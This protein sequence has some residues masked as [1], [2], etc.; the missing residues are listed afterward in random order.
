VKYN[1]TTHHDSPSVTLYVELE[2]G[3][4][5]RVLQPIPGWLPSKR[6]LIMSDGVWL[7]DRRQP[8]PFEGKKISVDLNLQSL[9][10]RQDDGDYELYS[11]EYP[12]PELISTEFID[13]PESGSYDASVPSNGIA[14]GYIWL[15]V[16]GEVDL[17]DTTVSE[18]GAISIVSNLE[19]IL[20]KAFK[21]WLTQHEERF[22]LSPR[23]QEFTIGMS[24]AD[25]L[26][27]I[28]Q[29]EFEGEHALSWRCFRLLMKGEEVK[30]SVSMESLMEFLSS[31]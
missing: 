13:V 29:R 7:S 11:L 20:L 23:I 6:G 22:R 19:W 21:R 10:L 2:T 15:H 25:L 9:A 3:L 24:K 27:F 5:V 16:V 4:S 8:I 31:I 28:A 30:K 14:A 12:A 1:E 17:T 26:S 18:T